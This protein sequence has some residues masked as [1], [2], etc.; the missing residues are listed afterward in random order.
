MDPIETKESNFVYLG[1]TAEIADLPCRREG[2]NTFSVWQLT[3]EERAQ[4]AA[5]GNIRL[6]IYRAVP[7]PPVSLAVVANAG[8]FQRVPASCSVCGRESDDPVH[9]SGDGTHAYKVASPYEPP[10]PFDGG[11]S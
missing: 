1:P 8:C 10:K 6:G 9:G 11:E 5:G 7:I 4:I 3:A 2:R